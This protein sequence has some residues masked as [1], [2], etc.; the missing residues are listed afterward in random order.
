[1]HTEK[2]LNT[3]VLSSSAAV[4]CREGECILDYKGRKALRY[5]SY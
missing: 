1:M 3:S 2:K 5:F 4:G